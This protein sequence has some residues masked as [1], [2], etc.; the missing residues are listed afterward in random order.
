MLTIKKVNFSVVELLAAIVLVGLQS[1][2]HAR[3]VEVPKVQFLNF[4]VQQLSVFQ[5][6]GSSYSG[7]VTWNPRAEVFD[8]FSAG[9]SLG[10]SVLKGSL[11]TFFAL[12]Y[13]AV[14][15][16]QL[17]PVMSADLG[18]GAQTWVNNG[19]TH[20]LVGPSISYHFDDRPVVFID[21]VVAGYS[22]LLISTRLTHEVRIG[23]GVSF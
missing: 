18:L 3:Q 23:L 21:R 19:G 11:S 17:S 7:V 20:F 12:E 1:A 16:Y 9:L 13:S 10:S 15:T 2:A 14:A 4:R 22:A 8:R 6:T 5:S